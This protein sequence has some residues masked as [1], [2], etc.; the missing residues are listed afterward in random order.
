MK[1]TRKYSVFGEKLGRRAGIVDMMDNLSAALSQPD[2]KIMLGGGNPARL[3]EVSELIE[4]VVVREFERKG[5]FFDVICN[6]SSP[7]GDYETAR[8]VSEYLQEECGWNV[9]WRNIFFCNGSQSALF[10]LFNMLAG[11]N[12][13]GSHGKVMLP[14]VPEYIGYE[15]LFV[16]RDSF[17]AVKPLIEEISEQAFRYKVDT[18][19]VSTENVS[20]VAISSPSN[21]TGKCWGRQELG[22][23]K[24]LC[25]DNGLPLIYDNAYGWPFPNIQFDD[26][27]FEWDENMIVTMSLSK[28]GMP[29]LRTGLVVGNEEIVERL[30][31]ISAVSQLSPNTVGMHVLRKLIAAGTLQYV[32]KS[33]VAPFYSKRAKW[34]CGLLQDGLRGY[35]VRI[36]ES[37]GTMF[38]W[39]WM[40]NMKIS[41]QEL[42]E[43]LKEKGVLTLSGH[44]F[45]I[46]LKQ[47]AW[48]HKDECLRLTFS[49]PWE[50]VEAG[51]Q[52]VI[53]EIKQVFDS[54]K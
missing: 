4:E 26:N 29:G 3:E 40:K 44:H 48:P 5:T 35:P 25:K 10:M 17:E 22:W 43:R 42:Y 46:G 7:K 12:A 51:V 19:N 38:V 50:K 11:R 49:Q 52:I 31:F 33:I 21:P 14:F 1:S 53:N 18:S 30:R 34:V 16:E 13:Q 6:Y 28:I 37:G 15:D 54:V 45:F 41:S 24:T 32:A 47:T 39:L 23:L 20:C 36:H 27:T 9:T 8:V 2:G